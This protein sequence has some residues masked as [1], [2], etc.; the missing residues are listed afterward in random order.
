MEQR[1]FKK[2][3]NCLNTNIYSYL[4]TY[5]GQN[6]KLNLNVHFF[7]TIR[8][9]WQLKTVVILHRCLIHIVLLVAFRHGRF[10][11]IATENWLESIRNRL[12]LIQCKIWKSRN[13]TYFFDS[14]SIFILACFQKNRCYFDIIEIEPIY[15]ENTWKLWNNHFVTNF[16]LFIMFQ[17]HPLISKNLFFKSMDRLEACFSSS[18]FIT[19]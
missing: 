5:G 3:N 10:W 13:V 18:R 11:E 15:I 12:E 17:V 6:Y 8:H 16:I 9:L 7:N 14:I 2:V 19:D 1:T 4:K